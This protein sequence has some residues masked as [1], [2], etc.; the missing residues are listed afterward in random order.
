MSR[1]AKAAGGKGDKTKPP[2]STPVVAHEIVPGKFNEHDWNLMLERDAAEDFALDYVDEIM[3]AT[4]DTIYKRYIER[5]LLPFTITQAKDAILQIIEWRFLSRD[6]GERNMADSSWIQ[7][8]EPEAGVTDCWA[9]GSV[10]RTEVPVP[11]PIPEEAEEEVPLVEELAKE[12]EQQVEAEEPELEDNVSEAEVEETTAEP[13]AAAAAAEATPQIEEKKKKKFK[14]YRGK[15][16]SPGLAKMTESLDETEMK[17]IASEIAASLS[18]Q[19]ITGNLMTMP[20][21]CSSIL[22]VQNGRPPG[23]KDVEY[24][25]MG[26]VVAVMK[27][28][29]ER[30]PSHRV[31]VKYQVVD[32]A[33][34]A[35]QARL[36]AMRRGRFV[37]STGAQLTKARSKKSLHS[38]AT[39][40]TS[41]T[42]ATGQKGVMKA[43][44]PIITQLPPSLIETMEVAAGVQVTEAGRT[45]KGPG[46]YVRKSDVLDQHQKDLQPVTIRIKPAPISVSDLLDRNTPIL[47]PM[48]ETPPLPPIVPQ[49]PSNPSLKT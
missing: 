13:E 7:D 25:E 42:V 30:L 44:K 11:S 40:S 49:P 5:Q 2:P 22:K 1:A 23:N 21:S 39:T 45:K 31:T 17:I 28:D 26:N 38:D 19:E 32:P 9:Q 27:L 20:A 48:P 3:F 14:P 46:R 8:E 29:A 15:L 33:V 12:E 24:D 35:A 6:E 41:A 4:M 43:R 16:K 34:E 10:P 37:P 36:E 18:A 47:R